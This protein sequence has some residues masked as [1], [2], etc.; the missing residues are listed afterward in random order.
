MAFS[1]F[2]EALLFSSCPPC[3]TEYSICYHSSPKLPPPPHTLFFFQGSASLDVLSEFVVK[4]AASPISAKFSGGENNDCIVSGV[5]RH[6]P[7]E[8]LQVCLEGARKLAKKDLIIKDP[9]A[10]VEVV[11]CPSVYKVMTLPDTGSGSTPVWKETFY[12]H[13]LKHYQLKV[14]R[15]C[16]R[17]LSNV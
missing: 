10:M 7:S 13:V 14:S 1:F 2:F 3:N 15:F 5:Y 8:C 16:C 6:T 17:T 12:V 9:F 11:N 4:N